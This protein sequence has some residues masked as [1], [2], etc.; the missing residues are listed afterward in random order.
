MNNMN[1]CPNCGHEWETKVG[2]AK[3]AAKRDLKKGLLALRHP[4]QSLKSGFKKPAFP[5]DCKRNCDKRGEC[6]DNS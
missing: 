1:K 3:K 6:G 5:H 2:I 4:V